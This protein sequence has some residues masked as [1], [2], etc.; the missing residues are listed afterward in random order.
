VSGPQQTKSKLGTYINFKVSEVIRIFRQDSTA[1]SKPPEFMAPNLVAI[2]GILQNSKDG[3]V[4]STVF[5]K[6]RKET[7]KPDGTSKGDGIPD[8]YLI[9]ATKVQQE[10]FDNIIKFGLKDKEFADNLHKIYKGNPQ[11]LYI[12]QSS[13]SNIPIN[14]GVIG[15]VAQPGP[16]VKGDF[17]PTEKDG[18]FEIQAGDLGYYDVARGIEATITAETA[19]VKASK[20][21]GLSVSTHKD[22]KSN[23]TVN[24]FIKRQKAIVDLAKKMGDVYFAR[25][26]I[27][28]MFHWDVGH[29]SW[30]K[31]NTLAGF[32]SLLNRTDQSVLDTPFTDPTYGPSDRILTNIRKKLKLDELTFQ[33]V[34][35]D[36]R[37]EQGLR[38]Y[39]SYQISLFDSYQG[40]LKDPNVNAA[41]LAA[42]LPLLV[43]KGVLQLKST[44]P[45]NSTNPSDFEE[46]AVIG[47]TRTTKKNDKSTTTN[48]LNST[49]TEVNKLLLQF[50]V[51][52]GENILPLLVTASEAEKER[53][54]L[55]LERRK[56]DLDAIFKLEEY[57]RLGSKIG[58]TLAGF[59]PGDRKINQLLV[60]PILATIG[61]N[62]F[63]AVANGGAVQTLPSNVTRNV[64][65]DFG[66]ELLDEF[67]SAGI[68]ALS[69][70][71]VAEFINAIGI[72]G[73]AGELVNTGAG[74][75]VGQVLTNIVDGAAL[76]NGVNPVLIANAVGAFI[77]T[78][79]AQ[80]IVSFDTIGGQ[81]GS[82]LGSAVG[83]LV[84]GKIFGDSLA[85]LGAAAGP[86][87]IAIGAFVGFILGGLIGSIFGGTPRSGADVEYIESTRRFNVTNAYAKKGGNK[88]AAINMAS[89]VA[90]TLNSVLDL[91]GSAIANPHAVQTG[92]YGMRGS[93]IVYRPYSTRDKSAI[94]MRWKGRDAFDNATKFG[95]FSALIDRDFALVGGDVFAKRAFYNHL[96]RTGGYT[97]FNSETLYSDLYL[98]N[99][100]ASYFQN[101]SVINGLIGISPSSAFTAGW[102]ITLSRAEELGLNKRAA[103]DW[104]GGFDLLLRVDS[105]YNLSQFDFVIQS[106]S[107]GE[108]RFLIND[109]NGLYL[110]YL[111]DTIVTS[112]ITHIQASSVSETIDL[113]TAR[114]TNQIGY[115][116]NGKLN[117]DI[118]V[119]GED[120]TGQ[121]NTSI[122]FAA[123]ALRA[124]AT[125]TGLTDATAAE[126]AEKFLGELSNG[127]GVSIIGGAAEATIIDGAAAK[128]TLLVGRSYA[129]E[130]DGHAIFRLS[131]SKG[132]A[133]STVTVD[134]ATAA[135]NATAGTDYNG[136]LIE[137][138]AD[139]LT[140]WAAATSATFAANQTQLFA[141][142]A[143]TA[144]NVVNPEY[145]APITL[146]GVRI[147]EG[148]GKPQFLNVE[149]NERFTLTATVISADVTK[150]ANVADATT[151]AIAV[152]GTGTIVDASVGTTP[153][154]WI[155]NVIVDEALGS[156]VFSI[157][158]SRAGTAASVNFSTADRKELVIDVAATVDAGAGDDV[159][160]ASNLGDNIFGGEGNDTLYGGRLDDWLLGGDGDDRLNAGGADAG[161]LGGDGN[162]LN[163]GAGN[164]MLIGREGSDWL[165][166]GDGTDTLE[167][168][169]GG[170]ILA[171]GGGAGDVLR[172]GRGDDQYI[173]RTG[174]ATDT[175]R[176]E[177]GLSVEAVVTQRF[178]GQGAT[179]VNQRVAAAASGDLFELG[180]GLN[181]WA[182]GGVQ[183]SSQGVAAGGDDALVFGAGITLE[184]IKIFKS[185]DGE[186]LIVELWPEGVFG[187]DRMTMT[188]WFSSFNKI[189]ILRFADGNEVRIADFDTFILGSDGA[190]TIIGTAGND[191][192]HAGSG[193]DLVYLLSGND[194]GN[195]GLGNDTVSGDSGNDIVVGADGDDI[196]IG[197]FGNDTVSGGRG[198]DKVTGDS[199]NDIVSGGA[200]NDEVIGGEG[201]DIFK[202]QRGDGQDVFIDALSDEWELVWVSGT[203]FNT[204]AG[205]S[206]AADGTVSQTGF[207]VIHDGNK[208]SS[209][210]RIRYDVEQGKMWRHKPAN[211]D[212]TVANNGSD[213]IEFGL[214]IDINDIQFGTANAGKDLVIG[215]EGASGAVSG[216]ASLA[217]TITLKEW[218][219]SGNAGARGSIEKAVFFNTGAIDLTAH[220]LKGGTDGDDSVTGADARMNWLTGGIGADTLTG[221]GL[222]D[223]LN[224]NSGQDRLIGGAGSDVLMGGADNDTLIG[225]A[226][227]TRDGNT[228]AGDILIGGDGFDAASYETATA[229]VTASLSGRTANTGD[230]AGDV[231]DSIEGLRGSDHADIL[232]GDEFENEL[233]GGKGNDTLRGAG[234]DDLYIFGRGDGA[235][236]IIDELIAEE[237]VIVAQAQSGTAPMVADLQPPYVS[238]VQL[239]D[240]AGSVYQ[241]EHIVTNTETN[242]IIYRKEFAGSSTAVRGQLGYYSDSFDG[243]LAAPTTL[244]TDPIYWAKNDD[245]SNR[246]L[247][248]GSKIYFASSYAGAGTDT[249]LFEDY[250]GNAGVTGD[251]TIALSDLSFAFSGNDLVITLDA[252]GGSV[253]LK[254][255]KTASSGIN[256]NQAIETL[257]FSD[258]SSV[259]LAGLRFN[260]TTGA[261][262]ITSSDPTAVVDDFIVNNVV[263][264]STNAAATTLAGGAGNDTLTGG[265]AANRLDGGDGDD[266]LVGGDGADTLIGGAGIDTVSY[267]G[268]AAAVN[269]NLS[270]SAT[271]AQATV[272]SSE[273]SG[274][275]ISGVENAI[276]S[277]FGDTLTGNDGDNIL[278]G[279]RGDDTITGG[280][281][282]FTT[283]TSA[284]FGVGNDVLIGD[285]GNDT[286]RGGVGEDNLD[287][288]TGNDL[289]E[290]G[291]ERDV[292][293]GGD[294]ND[295]LRG[296][297]TTTTLATPTESADYSSATNGV[298]ILV[299]GN[300]EDAGVASNDVTQTYG[301]TSVDLPGWT[302][303][304]PTTI[305]AAQLFTT[306]SGVTGLTGTRAL[307]LDTGIAGVEFKQEVSGLREGETLSLNYAAAVRS[308]T[309]TGGFEILWNGVVVRTVAN[310]TSLALAAATVLQLRAKS[311]TNTLSFRATG[312]A[313]GQGSVIDN[314][315]LTRSDDQLIGGAGSDRLLGGGGNDVLLGGEGDDLAS[316]NIT[317]GAGTGQTFAAGLYGGAGDDILDG[318]TGNDTLN[319][320]IG[321]D[322]YIFRAGSGNDTVITNNGTP[323]TGG[324][325]D[326]YIFEDIASDK[327]WFTEVASTTATGNFDLIITAIGQGA[328]VTIKDWRLTAGVT[329]NLSRR[330][331]ASDKI[332]ARSDVAALVTAMAGA[333]PATWPTAPS[334]ALTTALAL[335][336]TPDAYVDRAVLIGADTTTAD[337]ITSSP[338][339]LGGARYEGRAGNDTI[340]ATRIF[341]GVEVEADDVIYGGAGSDIMTGGAGNDI[342]LFDT[343]TNADVITGGAGTDKLL[344]TVANA[345]IVVT[346]ISGI[347]E[348]S[349]GGFAGVQLT[350]GTTVTAQTLDLSAVTLSDIA[351]INGNNTATIA[352]TIIGSAGSDVIFG[353]AG[354]DTLRGGAGDDRISGGVG[355][356][357]HDGG[358]GVDTIDQSF[359]TT[360]TVESN[361]TINLVTGI[362][363]V[364]TAANESAVNFENAIGGAAIDTITGTTGANRLEGRGGNDV[365]DG[366]D[367][368]DVLLGGAGADVIKGGAGIDTASYDGSTTAVTVNLATHTLTSTGAAGGDAV[369]DKF[370]NIEN[371]IGGSGN[372]SL[373]GNTGDNVLRGGLGND[374]LAGGAG[375][376]TAVYAGNF[377]EYNYSGNTITDAI[378]T[379]GNEGTDTLNSIEFLQFADVRISLG[380]DPNNGPRLGQPSMLDQTWN[381]SA[382]GSY[383]IPASAFY[384]LDLADGMTFAA[385]LA[386]GSAL[387]S[388]LSFNATTR[389]FSGTPPVGVIGTVLDIKVT[390]TD[391]PAAGQSTP[392]SVSDNVLLTITEA[393]GTALTATAGVAL[394]GTFRRET[395]TGTTGNDVFLGSGGADTING[396]ASTPPGGDRMDYT[397]SVT[398]VSVSLATGTGSGGDAEGDTLISIEELTGSAFDDSLTGNADQNKLYGGAGADSIDGG[399]GD[400]LIDGG[401][402][403]DS[404]NGGAGNDTLMARALADG[405]LE[406]QIDGGVGVDQLQ[407]TDSAYG[408]IVDISESSANPVGIEHVL[409]SNFADTITGNAFD[410][411]LS[412]G[413]GNDIIRGGAGGDILHGDDGNDTVEG[414]LGNDSVYG[415]AG[416]DR[417]IGGAGADTLY[418]GTGSDTVDYRTSSAGVNVNLTTN[419]GLG[420]DA[421]G[422]IYESG[423][424][425][426]IAGSDHN[427]VL[428]GSSV[429]NTLRGFSGN[430]EFRGGAG[431]DIFD[432]G[433]GEDKIVYTGNRADYA[434]D[435]VAKTVRH[436]ATNE[437]DSFTSVESIQFADQT[438][439]SNNQAP[440]VG[441]G[442]GNQT[443]V[444]NAI[445]TYVIPT[446]AFNDVDGNQADAYK[447]LSFTATLVGGGALPSWLTF[448]SATKTFSY[449]GTG[450]AIGSV[451]AVRVTAFD[452][453]ASITSDFTITFTEGPGATIT[454]TANSETINGTF[455][456]EIINALD[457]DD[458]I[459]GSAGADA[460]NGGLGTD[461]VSYATS[462]AGVTISLAGG[463]G[464]GGDAQGDT[465]AN[466]ENLYGSAFADAL[467]GSASAN[468]IDADSGDDL[469]LAG[470]GSD[471]LSGG[472]G[473]D[474][475][476]GEAG[477]DNLT[478]GLGADILDGGTGNDLANYYWLSWGRSTAAATNGV[479]VDLLTPANNTNHAAGDTYLSIEN[480]NGTSFA[481][482]LRG[483]DANNTLYGQ[484]GN[485]VLIGRDGADTLY[486]QT[487]NDSLYGDAGNDSVIG[488][489]GDDLLIGGDGADAMD[490]G[491][492]SDRVS[493]YWQSQGVA[494]TTGVTVDM[495]T[496]SL[497]LGAALN[498]TFVG[499]E[500]IT[501]TALGDTIRGDANANNFDGDAGNDTLD[502][503]A[504]NDTLSG[505]A[506]NDTLIGGDGVDTLIGGADNDILTGG[507]GADIVNGEAGADTINVLVVG[508]DT[509][510]GG[511]GI[512]TV[513]F[514]ATT[515]GIIAYLGLS[516]HKL[517]NIENLT[518][519]SGN[520]DLRGDAVANNV[521]GGA[522]ND[523]VMGYAGNDTLSGGDG[524]DFVYGGSGGDTVNGGAGVDYLSYRFTDGGAEATIGVNVDLGTGAVSG[525]DAAGDVI[526]LGT[527][528]ALEGTQA[529]DVLRGDALGNSFQG[530]GGDDSI[531]GMAGNDSLQGW[532]GN[533]ILDG[534]D[535]NDSIYGQDG[536]DTVLGGLGDDT[537]TGDAG[538]D[539]LSGGDGID[540]INGGIGADLLFGDAGDDI[541]V[542]DD[543][544]D[545]LYGGE[546]ADNLQGGLGSDFAS[547]AF[548]SRNVAATVGVEVDLA[549]AAQNE[550]LSY[551][552]TY[553]SIENLVGTGFGD[554]LHGDGNANAI[555]AGAGDD[556][557]YGRAGNDSL[558]GE[559]GNDALYGEAG[560][561]TL[562]G[563]AGTDRLEGGDGNDNL[564]GGDGNDTLLGQAGVDSISGGLGDDIIHE[565][566]FAQDTI[567][568]GAGVDTVDYAAIATALTVNLADSVATKLTNVENII[569]GSGSDSITG[570][571]ADNRLEG[572]QGNDTLS[573]AAGNDVLVGGDGDDTLNGGAGA[574]NFSGGVGFDTLDYSSAATGANFNTATTV[575]EVRLLNNTLIE[576]GQT[577]VLNGVYVHLG[578]ATLPSDGIR[579]KNSD[580][581]GDTFVMPIDIERLVGANAYDE[582][583]GNDGA[584]VVIGGVNSS[585]TADRGDLIY[586]GNGNDTLF[587]DI[588]TADTSLTW[589]N[590]V[591]GQNWLNDTTGDDDIIY[592]QGG[593]DTLFGGG[594][595]DR[596][597]GDGAADTLFGGAGDDYLDAGDAGDQ[598]YGGTG[599]D[600]MIGGNGNDTYWL[601]RTSGNDIIYNY[602]SATQFEDV[603]QYALGINKEHLWFTKVDGTRDLKVKILGE[604]SQVIIKDWFQNTTAG[605]FNN[606][607]PQYVL[608]LFIAGQSTATTVDSL[609]QLLTIMKDITEPPV[610]ITS[611]TPAQQTAINN[612]WI[613]NTPPTIMAD[614]ANT[615]LTT[616]NED[617]TAVLYFNVSDT[618]SPLES[619][620]VA[621]SQSGAVEVLSIAPVAGNGNEG[622]RAV[623]VRGVS[624]KHGTGTITLTASDSVFN[625]NPFVTNFT[626][627]AVANGVTIAVLAGAG[628]N[629][630]TQITL[631]SVV[632]N[633]TDND[634][635]E[636]VDS[637]MIDDVPVGATLTD[638]TNIF[639]ATS[640][641]TSVEIKSWNRASLKITPPGGSADDFTLKVRSR[642]RELSNNAVSAY[643][644]PL[645]TISVDVNGAPTSVNFAPQAFAENLI[646]AA[647]GGT[648][649][650]YLSANDPDANEPGGAGQ[651]SYSIVGGTQATKF[652]SEGSTL[653]LAAGQS[654][655][656]EAGFAAVDIRVTD[657]GGLSYTRSITDIRP[658][659]INEAASITSG[660]SASINENVAGPQ[661]LMTLT[662]SDLDGSAA[663][664]GT[665]GHVWSI[666]AGDTGKFE[667][668]SGVLRLKAGVA[669]DYEAGGSHNLTIRV[670][671]SGGLTA[672]QAFTVNVGNLNEAP[673]ITSASSGAIAENQAGLTPILALSSSDSDG[674]NASYGT[675]SHVWSIASDPSGK[676]EVAG[677][678]LRTKAGVSLDYA[679]AKNYGLTLRVTDGGGLTNDQAFT[680]NVSNLNDAPNS[681]S[682]RGLNLSATPR[683]NE[684]VAGVNNTHNVN[685]GVVSSTDPD[686]L[687]LNRISNDLTALPKAN[688]GEERLATSTGP[689][690]ASVQVLET[691]NNIGAGGGDAGGGV[692][693]ATGGAADTSKAYKFTIYFKPEN[694]QDH[695]LFFGTGGNVQDASTGAANSNPYFWYGVASTLVQDRWYKVEGYV[696]P[697]G[698]TLVGNDVYGGV[699]DTV[700]GAK[701]A[702]TTTFRFGTGGSETGT[703]FFSYYGAGTGYSA[704]WYQPVVE[705]L[706][707][708]YSLD[709]NAGGRFAINAATGLI[710][711]TGDAFNYEAVTSHNIVARVTD[712]GGLAKTQG[713]AVTVDN[714]NEAPTTPTTNNA[715]VT[716]NENLTGD[717][718]VRFSS[719]DP[720]GDTITYLFAATGTATNGK[721]SIV[722]GNQ[723][724]VN[725]ALNYEADSHGDFNVYATGNGQNS[726]VI[727][728]QVTIGNVNE[729]PFNLLPATASVTE[730]AVNG[731][732]VANLTGSDPEG[733]TL[734]WSLISSTGNFAVSG[735]NLVVSGVI[736]YEAAANHTVVVRASDG[737]NTTDRSIAISVGNV[738]EAPYDLRDIDGASGGSVTEN[739]GGYTGIRM[740]ADDP[741]GSGTVS[742]SITGGNINNWFSIDANGY[743]TAAPNIDREAFAGGIATL[744]ITATDNGGLSVASGN[745]SVNV[746]NVNEAPLTP[747][748]NIA[749]VT[750]NENIT[751][752]TSVTYTSAD[753]DGDAI[754]Y[755]FSATG[756][757][758]YGK[759]SLIGNQLHVNTA[760]DFESD[761][762][763]D[764]YIYANANGQ[765]TAAIRQQVTIGNVNEAP[766]AP[767]SSASP[768]WFYENNPYVATISGA[769]DPEG[770]DVTYTFA[771]GGN[772]AGLFAIDND[773]TNNATL[774]LVTAG[775]TVDYETVK[776]N[777]GAYGVAYFSDAGPEYGY[778]RW[779]VQVIATDAAGNSS[780]QAPVY[781]YAYNRNEAPTAPAQPGAGSIAENATGNTGI[782]FSGASDQDGDATNY[783]FA[784]GTTTSGK[785]SIVSGNQLHVNSAFD[786]EDAAQRTPSVTVYAYANGQ[787]S[788]NGVTATVNVTGVD[789]TRSTITAI[790][791]GGGFA[792]GA[793]PED[794]PPG[795]TVGTVSV[796]DPDTAFASLSVAVSDSRLVAVRNDSTGLFDLKITGTGFD[797]ETLTGNYGYGVGPAFAINEITLTPSD[798]VG[799]G[800]SYGF[801]ISIL[802]LA[803]TPAIYI[804]NGLPYNVN[805]TN[806]YYRGE[807]GVQL[808]GGYTYNYVANDIII[809]MGIR[810]SETKLYIRNSQGTDLTSFVGQAQ[811]ARP[812]TYTY[813][814]TGYSW[815]GTPWASDFVQQLPPIVFDLNG[816]GETTSNVRVTFD[817]DGNG[818]K[819][820]TGWISGGDAFLALDRNKD[821]MIDQGVE[822]SFLGDK[823]GARTDLEG[824]SA[825]DS[826]NDDVFDAQDARFSEFLVWQDADEDGV[827]DAGELKSLAEAGIA[828]IKLSSTAATPSDEG[829]VVVLGTSTFT[830]TDGTTGVVG[831]VALRWDEI[832]TAT[833]TATSA[834]AADTE[835]VEHISVESDALLPTPI[836][837]DANG[838]GVIDP[839][840]EVA[841]TVSDAAVFDSNDDGLLNASDA[842]YFD[843][844]MW[845]DTNRN[846]RAEL[847]ELTGIDQ[848]ATPVIDLHA[849]SA[850]QPAP[851]TPNAPAEST[852][853]TTPAAPIADA[854]ATALP[855]LA[856]ATNSYGRKAGKFTIEAR[857][858]A[859]HINPRGS[860]GA[861]D[862]RANALGAATILNFKGKSVGMLAPIVL[863]LDGDGL[864]LVSSKKSNARFDMDGNGVLDDTGWIG[865]GDGL[866]VIDRN[867]DGLITSAAELSFLTE[868]P[869]AKSDLEALAVLDANKDGKLDK[870]D[871]RF[872][873]F[874]VWVDTNRNGKTDSGELQTLE[875]LGI[876]EI[877]LAGRATNN[878]AKVGQNIV[879]ATATFTR[880]NGSVGTLGDVAFAF[881]PSAKQVPDVEN[882]GSMESDFAAAA[883]SGT[884]A[885]LAAMRAATGFD[886]DAANSNEVEDPQEAR[887]A[888]YSV[889]P[890]STDAQMAQMLQ[891]MSTFGAASGASDK[892]K[893]NAMHN[894]GLDWVT[895]SAV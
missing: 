274:D 669:L 367:G 612:A 90:G 735:T 76:F 757:T 609:S 366:G 61:E 127:T 221:G 293:V 376:D 433:D 661:N 820:N 662:S 713:F 347:E 785:L 705:K 811:Y 821:G 255:F 478:G 508:E 775:Q 345:R 687:D 739:S 485:D 524:D 182:G 6:G 187:G 241:F 631:P 213:I 517:T 161:T 283:L 594:G 175:I 243:E 894:A 95:T 637:I 67:K 488:G 501:G 313:D 429:A 700:T 747:A 436:I 551:G 27:H 16:N 349:G 261:L 655:D 891:A 519:G 413:L 322:S 468:T 111:T 365:I 708:S 377:S 286:L 34:L 94:T 277:Q 408:A 47:A 403:A 496:A 103:S 177:S 165:E 330:I 692:Y 535:G 567:D 275:F 279:L 26:V 868:K 615:T 644:D 63:E 136:T 474:T 538:D 832:A 796:S 731:V 542:G 370:E 844:R 202:Y 153:L 186:D 391:V 401:A 419:A 756:T 668:V 460:I 406:D 751:G 251:Q 235:D 855:T 114:L 215:I 394:A 227:G 171:G 311:G 1:T 810:I 19:K 667:I 236:I 117:D 536:N 150:L 395:M 759:Y 85:L 159:V 886:F 490:G 889:T 17:G 685:I 755:Y 205:Y 371:L 55:A 614:A 634:G 252:S 295:I 815:L 124:S 461:I 296:D 824:L 382:A 80:Q 809:A 115:T 703:R 146:D 451:T 630:G 97:N 635:S 521:Q 362:V 568:G 184:D 823:P 158:R 29:N 66:S 829:G 683:L 863:D 804:G 728:Q 304:S 765:N 529:A 613:L 89:A 144:D 354:A 882:S 323:T 822:I 327:L 282:T 666:A 505:G 301:L 164:D 618:H 620:T 836:A 289:L 553:N 368:D 770:G 791:W 383:T 709:D 543:G 36:E 309:A 162:Y 841:R 847:A 766:N 734:S 414:G 113:R 526:A 424:I 308:A 229:G 143:V 32:T 748:T 817:I 306:A 745:I 108:R 248:N 469:V 445:F 525:G 807:Q 30:P 297:S 579:A 151:G 238:S 134:L 348:I 589:L 5:Y 312:T 246:F 520:D 583:Y 22:A 11:G 259:S 888:L 722:N 266:W 514:A 240:R 654:L 242:E 559:D 56:A 267:A 706:D 435:F 310:S 779:D 566:T 725:T 380:I 140:G 280:G 195:G 797:Y 328:T 530:N 218:G 392:L 373:T 314:V 497:G 332:L 527:F 12:L 250:T 64:F 487:G 561:D 449:I 260:P 135:A 642:S 760:L 287:G 647:S 554:R 321:V 194:F 696:L 678:V 450:A 767:S 682:M 209:S 790:N 610:A 780:I 21:Y 523:Y 222:N 812:T 105:G 544:D 101:G 858:G 555:Y 677:N 552:D 264:S 119:T 87:G 513:S 208:W 456:A 541:I 223:I 547:Y 466:I 245:G 578:T 563:N 166:G 659:N 851:A 875:Q 641:V 776:A 86:V 516:A 793:I 593:M 443:K 344:A 58:S 172:G 428:T 18:E 204:A 77:G 316:I 126:A 188:D 511:T 88:G 35:N 160:H 79:L 57:G 52:Y 337:T 803:P 254:N 697:E 879:L 281:G 723:L 81:I 276:G 315:R 74:A 830:R 673:T 72:D 587:G 420:G 503:R 272:A 482:E 145:V 44:A 388:W 653:Y 861:L 138:S 8:I 31:Q 148:N 132:I 299:N 155:D 291:A 125:V 853:V 649:V 434:I 447:G 130:G 741:E 459:N 112:E 192:V 596:L 601:S 504:G 268:S 852:S 262:V 640:G 622:R 562:Q 688:W 580:A 228:A 336:Q 128:P 169:D 206:L 141:R 597:F 586:G 571:T 253:T 324:G 131:L 762:P 257:Q 604:T 265:A 284:T 40:L 818:A 412:G 600:T 212:A 833:A 237:T 814:L 531:Y 369:G 465:L 396:L 270:L 398:G 129:L 244:D 71:L 83:S 123:T 646:G 843:L 256:T 854:P 432:G 444:D 808:G 806:G 154:A 619:L 51:D 689:L 326:D 318:G 569:G 338:I 506:G 200:G 232:E 711:A 226:G 623:T 448:N 781:V 663:V 410:N 625:S 217:D 660:N 121:T 178:S 870:T 605:D 681:L 840:T 298:S 500:A 381:D 325:L 691:G 342:F 139:G 763:G 98:A 860:N 110:G 470:D 91:T 438:V 288:G 473:N 626:V 346:S 196:V 611:L 515:T 716:F 698:S 211:A 828:S 545:Y 648:V 441:T 13:E 825:F 676:F 658:T 643:T 694:N 873:E 874:K 761:A 606:N 231:Y 834:A 548:T 273:S 565:S 397:G 163:G 190:D 715:N 102:A 335:W 558:L 214:G 495:V 4:N 423:S 457:G 783:V 744:N 334:P 271:T 471:I 477:D 100:Y 831:D 702:N 758:T 798:T 353:N 168:G 872:A 498:D 120:F 75:V 893:G 720:D 234:G 712:S 710:T 292:L 37:T 199:G 290:G 389:T 442:L 463:A 411:R 856:F 550:G 116:V 417:L 771:A 379:N 883:L 219:P 24:D 407:L 707:N 768:H 499:I 507:L 319:G 384:D 670:T 14:G 343:N 142:V 230:A 574:D 484:E 560:D 479:I 842:R 247:F 577:R 54:E 92:N 486:G 355:L 378:T 307:N 426:N 602:S 104:S 819:D 556:F 750:F 805:T 628:G 650:G 732:V 753:P 801:N 341:E 788:A 718:S 887:E 339:L 799:V 481:D 53:F 458:T 360:T 427:D 629:S 197:G 122:S 210:I 777:Q 895:A 147:R 869:D 603:V 714:V 657:S 701:I 846:G 294:G 352:E 491:A 502:G 38:E 570:T 170:D 359:I 45:L 99:D 23:E 493:Y 827:S 582:L 220:D 41:D 224:G 573:G 10:Q 733:T 400:D 9:G 639:N 599:N 46:T 595:K 269:V 557:V 173:F 633:L 179:V 859:L 826:N 880:S 533:D 329:T 137:V 454:G 464:T 746:I 749:N 263:Y 816:D 608:R 452:G 189:E 528:E 203:G 849:L 331:V 176:D 84:A 350:H 736:N 492:G 48:I 865:K 440:T 358:D 285:D 2:A 878:K 439:V 421:Q 201:S 540:N 838:N 850:V 437:I 69:S 65:S 510:D 782:I 509:I 584:S 621:S 737:V 730:N 884:D 372:D 180:S 627:N 724:H 835:K 693:W 39:K 684:Y 320:G 679:D 664:F 472:T 118:A 70:F 672:D 15:G 385:T 690:G 845:N 351:Q 773:G 686:S 695:Y 415:D 375:I 386:D 624:Q 877:G 794:L 93:D 800:G 60:S 361:Q 3:F 871:A 675:P 133:G 862:S 43:S 738:N 792:G 636:V 82:S 73:F 364:G 399:A 68:G 258:G 207:G 25:H 462:A 876:T 699:Y 665:G 317:A 42:L 357:A 857:S 405:T 546:G 198:N 183:T 772:P 892:L 866:L 152:S 191:F 585:Y 651:L 617:G 885:R 607:G 109:E 494:A 49:L 740:Y 363:K 305:P 62:L 537:I 216:F 185:A 249:L 156:A 59:I 656:Y 774:R 764:F 512:D 719:T 50:N 374:T 787:F 729:A 28:E 881:K 754:T 778:A 616:I 652:R 422:D 598:L 786:Y 890:D 393:A 416:D 795:T 680:V 645:A 581:Q 742:Y 181:N 564:Q 532:T 157:A 404:L 704:Q 588:G 453:Q 239:V 390:A 446:N 78:K 489:D 480:I 467:T 425:E 300:F 106:G 356:D 752:F 839:A 549:D 638:G 107:G 333:V 743:I 726:A 867:G 149:G 590:S 727:R 518:G 522:G 7:I 837:Y 455:R 402:G 591:A 33:G 769:S 387:P 431:N 576:A 632:L 572:G 278:R 721:Y 534:G 418:G 592:G 575:G 476:R 671:D 784:D 302:I 409:G 864:D 802:D 193:D 539:I 717:T 96:S 430:D 848:S 340:N 483:D 674:A 233:I 167:G 174:D 303:S 20:A 475:L 813:L 789:D 225:G